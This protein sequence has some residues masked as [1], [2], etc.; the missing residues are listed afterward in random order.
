M[1]TCYK[2]FRR[3]V[4]Q[5]LHLI[6]EPLRHRAR[7]HR[8]GRP[9]RLPRLR[10]ADQ[11][12]RPRVR[13][14]QEDR[15][16][17]R[18]L[19][20]LDHLQVRAGGRPGA[21]RSRLRQPPP[22]ARGTTATASG[23]GARSRPSIGDRVLEVGCGIGGYTGFL[24]NQAL[25]IVTDADPKNLELLRTRFRQNDVIPPRPPSTGARPISTRSARKGS[26]PSSRSTGWPRSATTTRR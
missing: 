7:D 19:G 23:Y 3:D 14:G 8:Q 16:E 18:R 24:R 4:L 15:L 10:G 21:A 5:P 2:V 26:T 25:A 6:V 17:G 13:G 11:L 9:P 1:E 22:R 20:D 12:L